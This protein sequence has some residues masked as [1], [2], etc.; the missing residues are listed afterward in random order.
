MTAL[1]VTIN[2]GGNLALANGVT[3]NLSNGLTLQSGAATTVDLT[4][5]PNGFGSSTPLLNVD[6]GNLVVTAG[7]GTINVA[8]PSV[9]DYDL[10]SYS[11]ATL[12]GG[13]Q[14]LGRF[15]DS[16]ITI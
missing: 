3:L 4:G 8:N 6:G 15:F 9:G 11:G 14:P 13:F 10:I 2:G 5:T 1:T 16:R 12:T 7:G